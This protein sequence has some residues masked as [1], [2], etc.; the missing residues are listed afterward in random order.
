MVRLSPDG[1]SAVESLAVFS[2]VIHFSYC[3]LLSMATRGA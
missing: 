3:L 2:F 1:V